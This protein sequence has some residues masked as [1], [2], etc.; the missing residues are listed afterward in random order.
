MTDEPDK[1]GKPKASRT[2]GQI[3]RRGEKKAAKKKG[4]RAE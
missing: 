4:S 1:A 3:V 2:A